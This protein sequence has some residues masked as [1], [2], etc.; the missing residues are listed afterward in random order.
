M[1]KKAGQLPRLWLAARWLR[2]AARVRDGQAVR[3]QSGAEGTEISDV[4]QIKSKM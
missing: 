1:G 4:K 3:V 2:G